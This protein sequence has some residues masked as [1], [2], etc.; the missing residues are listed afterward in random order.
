M[1]V[2]RLSAISLTAV[3]AAGLFALTADAN[4][5]KRPKASPAKLARQV[6]RDKLP[7]FTPEREAAALTFVRAYHPELAKLLEQLK[8]MKRN[9]YE[10][11]IR[12]LFQ[13][14]ENLTQVKERDPKRYAFEL[15]SWQLQ[16][17]IELLAARL[18]QASSSS[19][20]KELRN[21][22]EKQVQSEIKRRKS[23]RDRLQSQLQKVE[24]SI[25]ELEKRRDQA[26]ESR[27]RKLVRARS[28]SQEK[29]ETL[30]SPT[31]KKDRSPSQDR[32]PGSKR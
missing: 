6:D 3:V 11:A 15:E 5:V 8:T 13:T 21:L 7:S 27:F 9:E 1:R 18:S 22:L 24:T 20:E 16:S 32:S 25:N 30:A 19:L 10:H 26:V 31:S 23:E 28:K 4:L 12:E 29:S 2:S 14:S 17:R